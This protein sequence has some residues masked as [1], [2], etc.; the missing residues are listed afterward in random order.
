MVVEKA[1]DDADVRDLRRRQDQVESILE[2]TLPP[3]GSRLAGLP[4][5]RNSEDEDRRLF[6]QSLVVKHA[7][8][9]TE[10]D[11]AMLDLAGSDGSVETLNATLDLLDRLSDPGA[12]QRFEL[13]AA[14]AGDTPSA[15]ALGKYLL[16]Q[17]TWRFSVDS[18]FS[19]ALG[20]GLLKTTS[21]AVTTSDSLLEVGADELQT[22]HQ[23]VDQMNAAAGFLAKVAQKVPE[24][25]TADLIEA[26][27]SGGDALPA[28]LERERPKLVCLLAA[29]NEVGTIEH[30]GSA[31]SLARAFG[32]KVL[33]DASQAAGKIPLS[34]DNLLCDYMV[35]SGAKIYGLSRTAA[36]IS[37]RRLDE[38]AHAR[39][40]SPDA[41]GAVALGT[42]CGLR[43]VEMANDECRIRQLRDTFE[44]E[45]RSAF[46]EM[47]I[48]G[49]PDGRLAGTSNFAVPG[50]LSDAVLARLHGRVDI[51]SGAACESRTPGPSHVLRAMGASDWVLDGSLRVGIG[52]FTSS[53]ELQEGTRAIIEAIEESR[54][55][56]I[57]KTA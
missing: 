1:D 52:K 21:G 45:L 28:V 33:V 46:P 35:L 56:R 55:A 8:K 50:A 38:L 4:P 22:F 12:V 19:L 5:C 53:E 25:Q 3:T 6:V 54:R 57:R 18:Y 41:A 10:V 29:N 17:H 34:F 16:S 30:L 31:I 44:Q 24:D 48:N 32:A 20:V 9:L 39:F 13:Y 14:L 7:K 37:S 51:S 49:D 15:L 40:G 23:W 26:I 27:V 47:V 42:A 36:V 43:A 11:R 2:G